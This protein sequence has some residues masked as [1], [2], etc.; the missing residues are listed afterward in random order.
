MSYVT[1]PIGPTDPRVRTTVGTVRGVRYLPAGGCGPDSTP[2]I[3]FTIGHARVVMEVTDAADLLE[4]LPWVL[5]RHNDSGV[6]RPK[7]A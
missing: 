1:M 6:T 2:Y 4:A 3:E 7:A 5:A